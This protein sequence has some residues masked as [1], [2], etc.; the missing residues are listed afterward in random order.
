MR[1]KLVAFDMDGTLVEEHSC[2]GIIHR[3]F[4][5]Q[6]E[7][8]KNLEAWERGEINYSEFMRLDIKLWQP[9]PHISQVEEILS[10]FKLAP[11]VFG[12]V[13]KLRGKGYHVAIVT[14]GLDVLAKKVADRLK[15]EHVLANGIEVDERGYLTGEGIFRVE[16]NCKHEALEELVN[17]LRIRMDECVGV[18]DS[19]YD[20]NLFEHVGL[21]VAVGRDETLAR[22]ADVVIEDFEYFE[23][24]LNYL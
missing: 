10:N 19:K 12:V 16:P 6:Q 21:G 24:L 13:S 9:T 2:W 1:Y 23:Q 3:H 5:T 8:S 4:G 22:V 15:I 20:S 11:N 18:G 14:G 7:A 17:K